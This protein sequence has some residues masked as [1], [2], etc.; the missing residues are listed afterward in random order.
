VRLC[1]VEHRAHRERVGEK[2]EI[3]HTEKIRTDKCVSCGALIL[4]KKKT[5]LCKRCAALNRAPRTAEHRANLSAALRGRVVSSAT[6]K[7]ISDSRIGEKNMNWK[8]GKDTE[9]ERDRMS[10][11]NCRLKMSDGYI[12]A[13]LRM[14]GIIIFTQDYIEF[15]RACLALKRY[16]KKAGLLIRKSEVIR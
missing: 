15:T 11:H 13:L 10:E 16:I 12:R 14:R 7:K 4:N 1:E 5:F 6:R 2:A 9:K 8:G 3:M